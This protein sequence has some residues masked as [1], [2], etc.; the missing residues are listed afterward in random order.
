MELATGLLRAETADPAALRDETLSGTLEALT[1][2][3][4]DLAIGVVLE[5]SRHAA[6]AS[7]V[8][9][10]ASCS[11]VYAVAPH[12]PLAGATEP[13]TDE[14]LRQHRAVAAADSVHARPRPDHRPAGRPGRAD[15]ADHAGQAGGAVARPGWRLPAGADGAALYR[16]PAG[17]WSSRPSARRAW[18]MHYAWRSAGRAR[19]AGRCSGGWPSSTARPR[20]AHC[21]SGIAGARVTRQRSR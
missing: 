12:H 21:S 3:Q 8:A 15:G 6:P 5:P 18:P 17:W 1:S 7:A 14:V 13:L 10:W 2:G 16:Q 20:G 19:R 9:R 4:A 11:F